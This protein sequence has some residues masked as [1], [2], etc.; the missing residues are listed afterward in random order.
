MINART[1]F[2]NILNKIRNDPRIISLRGIF[3]F[4][5]ITIL[6]HV[7]YRFW[8]NTLHYYPIREQFTVAILFMEDVVLRQSYWIITHLL[9]IPTVLQDHTMWFPT[10]WGIVISGGCT[11]LKQM[12]QVLLLFLIYPGPFKHK[13]WFIPAGIILIHLTNITRITLLAV[14]MNLNLPHIQFIHTYPL[15]FLFYV[16]IFGM[17]VIWVEKITPRGRKGTDQK[18]I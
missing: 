1:R 15:R 5:L 18:P 14:A 13:A 3:L 6:I 8:A 10:K 16:V 4:F 7:S 17:W 2:L 9:Q 11:G 12:I